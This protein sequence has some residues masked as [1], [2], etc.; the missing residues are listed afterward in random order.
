[1]AGRDTLAERMNAGRP[2]QVTRRPFPADRRLVTAAMRAGRRTAPMYGLMDLDVTT[3]RQFLAASTPALSL[4]A[5]VVASVARAAA[6]HPEVHAYRDWRGQ[7]VTHR[8]VDAAT[9]IEIQTPQGPFGLPHVLRDADIRDV[10]DLSAE[11][12]RVRREPS[13]GDSGA[14]LERAAPV[15]T[16]IPG[17]VR[18]MYAIMA[19]SAA[20]RQ[21]VGTVAV[22]AVGMFAGGSGFGLAPLT[23]MPLEVVVGGLSARPRVIDGQIQIRDV[24]D[25]SLVIDHNVVDGAPAARFAARFRELIES[26]AVLG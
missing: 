7:V 1:M 17:A 18:A 21:R 25:V 20:L 22:T 9:L 3:A 14:W 2:R 12:R 11:M 16:R 23:L 10:A 8:H 6:E 26:A 24:L 4:T 5:F 19:R 15:A 13:S